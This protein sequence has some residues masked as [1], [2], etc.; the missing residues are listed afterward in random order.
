[1]N[2]KILKCIETLLHIMFLNNIKLSDIW[3]GNSQAILAICH[4]SSMYSIEAREYVLSE[5]EELV[6]NTGIELSLKLYQELNKVAKNFNHRGL[7]HSLE[8]L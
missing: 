2:S 5:L 4:T 7:Q 1:M 3:Q 6:R 8:L